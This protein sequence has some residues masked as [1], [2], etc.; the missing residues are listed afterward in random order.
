MN[1]Q[2]NNQSH[3]S[4]TA[5]SEESVLSFWHEHKIFEKTLEKKSPK[6][7]FTFYDGPPFATGLPHYGHLL[8]GTIKDIIPRYKTMQGYHVPR[9]WGWDCHGLPIENLIE[10]EL[11]LETKKDIEDYGIEKFNSAARNSV[12]RYESEWKR[13][14]PRSGRFVDME[15]AYMA[16]DSEYME[17]IWWVFSELYKKGLTKE[18]FKAMHLC[19]RC[20]TT[21]SN[22]EVNQ[23]YKDVTDITVT[24]KFELRDEPGT[25]L[26]AWTTT[27]WTLP[28]NVALAVGADIDY[29]KLKDVQI[30]LKFQDK[31]NE[32]KNIGLYSSEL[33]IV[34]KDIFLKNSVEFPGTPGLYRWKEKPE[35]TFQIVSEMKGSELA[36]KSYIAPFDYYQNDPEVENAENGWKVLTADFVTT[37]DGTG[38]VHIAPAF[39]SDDMQ[40]GQDNALPFIQHIS[41]N[42]AFKHVFSQTIDGGDFAGM[43]VKQKNDLMSTDIEIIKR[44]AHDGKLFSKQKIVHSYPHCWRCDTPLLNY[45]TTSWYVDVPRI[46]DT[47]IASNE[48]VNWVPEHVG[49]GRFGKWLEGARDWALSRS[50]FWGTPLPV[51]Y[52]PTTEQNVIIGSYD[53]LCSYAKKSGNTYYA[54]RHGESES[55]ITDMVN[56]HSDIHNPLTEK[57]KAQILEQVSALQE[58]NIHIDIILTSPMQRTQETAQLL[59]TGLGL[60]LESSSKSI[61]AIGFFHD[62]FT[63]RGDA[64]SPARCGE[65]K[66]F[67]LSA[68]LSAG[69]LFPFFVGL[70]SHVA[71]S[72]A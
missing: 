7:I 5:Q 53:E 24:A 39:G 8:A 57:G 65:L 66:I 3:K 25:F 1:N 19:P 42:G 51:W 12:L 16:M 27:P 52:N 11:G 40:L 67:I 49:D 22:F 69:V 64:A 32:I 47:L 44:L 63:T 45:A 35:S 18:G 31:S 60:S 15:N 34:S 50:R 4:S 59:R 26:L 56:A 48:T 36:G 58:K 10:K 43:L 68:S 9:K 13:Y 54:I 37:E 20:E 55:N 29:V 70:F 6:G 28:G 21:L 23:G 46:K 33:V 2:H 62:L 17:S 30:D 14:V 41:K 38:I 71:I 61:L 72:G